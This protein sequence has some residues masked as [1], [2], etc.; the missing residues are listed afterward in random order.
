[1]RVLV[2][3]NLLFAEPLLLQAL[4]NSRFRVF[5][6]LRALKV[7]PR[8]EHAL[9]SGIYAA[10]TALIART[11]ALE[12]AANN[13]ANIN[14]AGFK[15]QQSTFRALLA[16]GG[17]TQLDPLNQAINSFG[18][19]GDSHIDLSAG[20]LERTGNDLDLAIEG[21]GFF[22]VQTKAGIRY[23]RNG[24][25]QLSPQG[26]L[27][28]A[29]GDRVLG[30][31]GALRLPP[32]KVSISPDGTVS[33]SGALAGKIKVVDFAPG[34]SLQSEG[35]AMFTAPAGTERPAAN[36][37]VRQGM[38]ESSNVSPVSGAIGLI[39][40]Q[41]HAEML[42]RALTTFHSDFNRIAVQDLPRIA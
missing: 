37:R 16:E 33:V 20:N 24:R 30:E 35:A 12:L 34:T 17:N 22:A 38:L 41:R 15:S 21:A 28:S 18:L 42:Q 32:G 4:L 31:Q 6:L 3:S 25:L 23:T 14:T 9:N 13:L 2:L 1:M 36:A 39:A 26:E 29:Q 11:Q 40:L 5:G 19:L 10:C 7:V 8:K 27:I